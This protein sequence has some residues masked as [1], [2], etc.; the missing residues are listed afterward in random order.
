MTKKRL[1][2]IK[3]S[4]Q[5]AVNY[6]FYYDNPGCAGEDIESRDDVILEL[7]EIIELNGIVLPDDIEEIPFEEVS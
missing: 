6:D 5:E 2:T 3:E 4:A 7:I 1:M